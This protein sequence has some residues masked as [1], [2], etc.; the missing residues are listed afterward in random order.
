MWYIYSGLIRTG[1][2]ESKKIKIKPESF[3]RKKFIYIFITVF[4]K[5]RLIRHPPHRKKLKYIIVG[6]YII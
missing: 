3:F 6:V 2:T 5:L 1:S 4:D